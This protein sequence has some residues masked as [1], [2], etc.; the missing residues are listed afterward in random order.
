VPAPTWPSRRATSCSSG[1]IPGTCHA[2]SGSVG[3]ATGKMVQN[4]WWAAGYNVVA[5]PLAAGV[6]AREG[7]LLSP[8]IGAVLMSLST[9][10][11]AVNAQLLRRAARRGAPRAG[12]AGSRLSREDRGAR[13]QG[14]TDRAA[15]LRRPRAT[16]GRLPHRCRHTRRTLL[17][18][19]SHAQTP[20]QPPI[21]AS[22][23]AKY[24]RPTLVIYALRAQESGVLETAEVRHRVRP[25]ARTPCPARRRTTSRSSR[26]TRPCLAPERGAPRAA[27]GSSR[28]SPERSRHRPG[29]FTGTT[30][31]GIASQAQGCRRGRLPQQ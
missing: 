19:R 16:R 1:A 23:A 26:R 28:L 22:A 25:A 11:V 20:K 29:M 2:S 18:R 21:S 27:G 9:I 13:H 8:A 4:L 14:P 6:L 31:S 17:P 15:P 7:I 5:I 24:T 3:R 30:E 10:I 12:R